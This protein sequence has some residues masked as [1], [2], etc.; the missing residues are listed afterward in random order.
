MGTV[1]IGMGI[2]IGVVTLF[3]LGFIVLLL[4]QAVLRYQVRREWDKASE[5]ARE[6]IRHLILMDKVTGG[7]MANLEPI[8]GDRL[9]KQ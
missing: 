4:Y 2:V 5:E 6:E 7:P 8:L 9:N 1:D 3:V